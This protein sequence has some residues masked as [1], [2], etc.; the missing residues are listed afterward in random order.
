ML[1][2]V[3]E[4]GMV[5]SDSPVFEND[6]TLAPI[7]SLAFL[8]AP[9][10]APTVEYETT[11]TRETPNREER[12]TL[13]PIASQAYPTLFKGEKGS[14]EETLTLS[15]ISSQAYLPT[16]SPSVGEPSTEESRTLAREKEYNKLFA[17]YPVKENVL[18]TLQFV[19]VDVLSDTAIASSITHIRECLDE[20][21][22]TSQT[23]RR[24]EDTATE[25][26]L[27]HNVS[28]LKQTVYTMEDGTRV[29]R[30]Q[31]RQY[32]SYSLASSPDESDWTHKY[33]LTI[34]SDPYQQSSS[35]LERLQSN[36][37]QMKYPATLTF[38]SA[39]IGLN[40]IEFE[41]VDPVIDNREMFS[42]VATVVLSAFVI[43]ILPH[44]I[45]WRVGPQ[46]IKVTTAEASLME[47]S[48][49]SI[50]TFNHRSQRLNGFLGIRDMQAPRNEHRS[51]ATCNRI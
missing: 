32:M 5:K 29:N 33:P 16:S 43:V 37:D 13:A 10:S 41:R 45:W 47:S 18:V 51:Q 42:L 9:N 6:L 39:V 15:P 48:L 50:S 35:L 25:S 11:T 31:Y 4:T 22:A 36:I 38:V 8:P 21:Y 1:A 2:T 3:S 30:F 19:N 40:S 28:F 24:L 7:S 46:P 44:I 20:I 27:E 49:S 14:T 12:L 26:T 17:N 34:A 23:G